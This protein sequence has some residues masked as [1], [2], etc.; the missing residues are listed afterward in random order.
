MIICQTK[1]SKDGTY[2]Y[3]YAKNSDRWLSLAD[4]CAE[5]DCCAPTMKGRLNKAMWPCEA[6]AI[7]E[8]RGAKFYKWSGDKNNK[9]GEYT[10]FQ[11]AKIKKMSTPALRA[12]IKK[13][14]VDL[15]MSATRKELQAMRILPKKEKPPV[16]KHTKWGSLSG[17]R[18]SLNP[19]RI[20]TLEEKYAHLL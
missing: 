17:K 8:S 2:L 14:G 10:V 16:T 5:G 20:G 11:L 19:V 9:K 1:H 18:R 7:R 13:H 15:A 6:I 4:M 12:R 3:Q